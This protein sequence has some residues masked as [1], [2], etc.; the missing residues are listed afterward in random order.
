MPLLF[1]FVIFRCNVPAIK[2]DPLETVSS[3]A[4]RLNVSIDRPCLEI[5]K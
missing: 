5:A 4:D 3:V 2:Q 1:N